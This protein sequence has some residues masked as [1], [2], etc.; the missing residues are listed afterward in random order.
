MRPVLFRNYHRKKLPLFFL[1]FLLNARVIPIPSSFHSI[2]LCSKHDLWSKI[3]EHLKYL[4]NSYLY[5]LRFVAIF[6]IE[7]KV[8]STH[9]N[10]KESSQT[11][12]DPS[13]IFETQKGANIKIHAIK[14]GKN[15]RSFI[16]R[17]KLDRYPFVIQRVDHRLRRYVNASFS[18]TEE[19]LGHCFAEPVH[20]FNGYFSMLVG[21]HREARLLWEL[22]SRHD[23]HNHRFLW[24]ISSP[25]VR[26]TDRYQ[27]RLH[28]VQIGLHGR[29]F[30]SALLG[31][32]EATDS[33]EFPFGDEPT[34]VRNITIGRN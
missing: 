2:K 25:F 27:K 32:K 24:E 28:G 19:P 6:L 7:A 12:N 16:L 18:I 9:S 17:R 29:C 5:I 30:G 34:R 31:K 3:F 11:K 20:P 4:Y 33:G 15:E 1:P 23:V 14:N 10:L 21:S 26:S 13:S 8:P 22:V